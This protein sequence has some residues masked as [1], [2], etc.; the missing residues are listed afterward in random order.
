[1]TFADLATNL[2]IRILQGVNVQVETTTLQ[3]LNHRLS[4]GLRILAGPDTSGNTIMLYLLALLAFT[5]L[6]LARMVLLILVLDEGTES[7]H[8][9][10]TLTLLPAVEMSSTD[11]RSQTLHID[12]VVKFLLLAIIEEL[13]STM[14]ATLHLTI[15]LLLLRIKLQLILDH[16]RLTLLNL[17]AGFATRRG[18]GRRAARR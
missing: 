7:L 1:M 9:R 6:L 12:T 14:T 4:E 11:L 18:R 2:T 16:L 10:S 13:S 15:A 17:L 3:F 5:T 8:D